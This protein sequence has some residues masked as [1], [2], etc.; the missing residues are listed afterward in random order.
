[1]AQTRVNPTSAGDQTTVTGG[2]QRTIVEIPKIARFRTGTS[3]YDPGFG[4]YVV[5]IEAGKIFAQ[6]LHRD[7]TRSSLG[8]LNDRWRKIELSGYDFTGK[9]TAPA[10]VDTFFA[11]NITTSSNGFIHVSFLGRNAAGEHAVYVIRI[12]PYEHGP[13]RVQNVVTPLA[14]AEAAPVAPATIHADDDRASVTAYVD[15][16]GD[17][18]LMRIDADGNVTDVEKDRIGTDTSLAITRNGTEIVVAHTGEFEVVLER[19]NAAT[20]EQIG[21]DIEITRPED[22][23][24]TTIAGDQIL[25]DASAQPSVAMLR[26]NGRQ[27]GEYVVVWQGPGAD[28]SQDI[29][30]Q[31]FDA[32]GKPIGSETLVNTIVTDGAQTAPSVVA[33]DEGRFYVSWLTNHLYK[34]TTGDR[35]AAVAIYEGDGTR[36]GEN[37]GFLESTRINFGDPEFRDFGYDTKAAR[38]TPYQTTP[39]DGR[40]TFFLV[41]D[42]D[43]RGERDYKKVVSNPEYE[44]PDEVEDWF[45]LPTDG[46]VYSYHTL[47]SEEHYG[48][49]D[50]LHNYFPDNFP[51]G[52][53]SPG[54]VT[55]GVR[56]R[57][58]LQ[59]GDNTAYFALARDPISYSGFGFEVLG[60]DDADEER[61]LWYQDKNSIFPDDPLLA[62]PHDGSA[63]FL[64]RIR[65]EQEIPITYDQSVVM[66]RPVPFD[67]DEWESQSFDSFRT[68]PQ[69]GKFYDNYFQIDQP[70]DQHSV[71]IIKVGG[72][73]EEGGVQRSSRIVVTWTK[74]DGGDGVQGIF[75]QLADSRP[76]IWPL[77]AVAA[78]EAFNR[79]SIDTNVKRPVP[80]ELLP[81]GGET[82]LQGGIFQIADTTDEEVEASI[83]ALLNPDGTENGKFVVVYQSRADAADDWDLY[84]RIFDTSTG[85]AVPLGDAELL[86]SATA[87]DQMNATVVAKEGGGFLVVYQSNS[88][89]A[90]DVVARH[91]DVPDKVTITTLDTGQIAVAWQQPD[92]DGLGI[93]GAVINADGSTAVSSYRIS[94]TLA[95]DQSTPSIAALPGG[96]FMVSYTS[97]DDDGTGVFATTWRVE[98]NAAFLVGAEARLNTETAGDQGNASLTQ[99]SAG[100]NTGSGAGVVFTGQGDGEDVYIARLNAQGQLSPNDPGAADGDKRFP[101]VVALAEGRSAVVWYDAGG[102]GAVRAQLYS[103]AG[104]PEGGNIEIGLGAGAAPPSLAALPDGGF[105]VVWQDGLAAGGVRFAIVTADG[106]VTGQQILPPAFPGNQSFSPQIVRLADGRLV[107]AWDEGAPP[108]ADRDVYAQILEADGT[109][110][111]PP[112][113]IAGLVLSSDDPEVTVSLAARDGG[114]FVIAWTQ[115][116]GGNRDVI[117]RLVGGDGTLQPPFTVNTTLAGAQSEAQVSVLGDGRIL[118]VWQSAPVDVPPDEGTPINIVGRIFAAD[119]TGGGAEFILNTYTDGW[120]TLPDITALEGGGFVAVWSSRNEV[121]GTSEEDVFAQVFTAAGEKRGG[122]I[123]VNVITEGEQSHAAVTPLEDGGFII[124]WHS[125]E[126]GGTGYDIFSQRY[127]ADGQP[128]TPQPAATVEIGF[129]DATQ[130]GLAVWEAR[131][132]REGPPFTD[133]NFLIG[134]TST[135][136]RT[137]SVSNTDAT[138]I[139][140]IADY[141]FGTEIDGITLRGANVNMREFSILRFGETGPGTSSVTRFVDVTQDLTEG[142]T[143]TGAINVFELNEKKGTLTLISSTRFPNFAGFAEGVHVEPIGSD[144]AFRVMFTDFPNPDNPTLRHLKTAVYDENGQIQGDVVALDDGTRNYWA[145]TVAEVDDGAGGTVRLYVAHQWANGTLTTVRM[146]PDGTLGAPVVSENQVP[147]DVP[148][149]PQEGNRWIFDFKA[150]RIPQTVGPDKTWLYAPTGSGG[151]PE[152]QGLNRFEIKA[153]GTI[154]FVDFLSLPGMESQMRGSSIYVDGNGKV[155]GATARH[156]LSFNEDGTFDVVWQDLSLDRRYNTG[157]MT[158]DGRLVRVVPFP[159]SIKVL[160]TGISAQDQIDPVCFVRGTRIRTWRGEVRIEDLRPG[161]LVATFDAGLQPLRWIGSSRI[162]GRGRFAPVLI[163]AGTLGN[164]DD[165]YVSPQHR[166]LLQGWRAEILSGEPQVLA[167]AIDLVNGGT[168]RQVEVAEVEYFHLLFDAHQI[169]WSNAVPSESL[170]VSRNSV[171]SLRP[172]QRHEIATLF[173]ELLATERPLV[174]IVRPTLRPFEARILAELRLG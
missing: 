5:Y 16:D 159:D 119:G 63:V 117:A 94:G 136:Y 137:Y 92:G 21:V 60:D 33:D 170:H 110:A 11:P 130:H 53:L 162:A 57:T 9:G 169:V 13:P 154:E 134:T 127:S 47:S 79:E 77:E 123:L 74:E 145:G 49:V 135:G 12:D 167:A 111:D 18:R 58:F 35:V 118:F 41:E 149:D 114:G 91:F 113:L 141:D 85:A 67:L 112:F 76:L 26:M 32:D 23:V 28:G 121:S 15:R 109:P 152:T 14:V 66:D 90:H 82:V 122:P 8:T 7:G 1:M 45:P 105:A 128:L 27:T 81:Q 17:L 101:D 131:T 46:T 48:D 69:K 75:G 10:D 144:G 139:Q 98:G 64:Y 73:A 107:V 146:N 25:N 83:T 164:R 148:G 43:W 55:G 153:D 72:F 172:E 93:W 104:I 87:G 20:L 22:I 165:L 173:P 140:I 171:A 78:Y 147:A 56:D 174:A 95:G 168:I 89:G 19:Y 68:R 31:R 120:Q 106:G 40:L 70:G 59:I 50:Y 71:E 157:T 80:P 86:H 54:P 142:S 39:D 108:I 161:D 124:A 51:T 44:W 155:W 84:Y 37:S 3:A 132:I 102:P 160:D 62:P 166:I 115:D 24:N 38:V 52:V 2:G 88:S 138:D 100:G 126:D 103:A 34:D 151:F 96:T 133:R 129:E 42:V 65:N 29:F 36:I 61:V 143:T 150:V 99:S 163:E 158:V 125:E 156:L 97:P 4:W 30:Y 116:A 6:G